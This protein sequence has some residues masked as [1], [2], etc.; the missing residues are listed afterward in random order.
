MSQQQKA[1]LTTDSAFMDSHNIELFEGHG[2]PCQQEARSKGKGFACEGGDRWRLSEEKAQVSKAPEGGA[3]DLF[4]TER[5]HC[6]PGEFHGSRLN[7]SPRTVRIQK[8]GENYD[9]SPDKVPEAEDGGLNDF[10]F[11]KVPKTFTFWKWC[12]GLLRNV[13]RTRTPFSAFLKSSLHVP[14]DDSVSTSSLFPVPVPETGLFNRMPAC[15]SLHARRRL[16]LKRVLHIAAMALNY[17][18]GGLGS[19]PNERLLSRC[20]SSTHRSIYKKLMG[21]IAGD[22]PDSGVCETLAC[23]RK[24]PQLVAFGR[25]V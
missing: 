23:G 3:G 5:D 8:K 4:M 16:H 12:A 21:I 10:L 18:H 9:V 2:D 13:L 14:R 17:W 25:T 22:G 19:F 1:V 20:P 6:T 11:T 7:S 15:L 24:F